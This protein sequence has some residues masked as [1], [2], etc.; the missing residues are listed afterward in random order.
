MNFS[1][2]TRKLSNFQSSELTSFQIFNC[3]FVYFVLFFNTQVSVFML[4]F[5]NLRISRF[6]ICESSNPKFFIR[7]ISESSNIQINSRSS[8]FSSLTNSYYKLPYFPSFQT[9]ELS[10][11]SLTFELSFKMLKFQ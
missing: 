2:P 4:N 3:L 8:K 7:R 1:L 11:Y 9:F 10:N 5:P 6:F